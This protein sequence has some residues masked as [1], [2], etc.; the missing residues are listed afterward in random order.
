MCFISQLKTNLLD[1]IYYTPENI[2]EIVRT[3]LNIFY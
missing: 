1:F 3:F 2:K